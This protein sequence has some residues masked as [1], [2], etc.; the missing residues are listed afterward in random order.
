MIDDDAIAHH[1]AMVSQKFNQ[2]ADKSRFIAVSMASVQELPPVDIAIC[3]QWAS[4]YVL[5]KFNKTKRKCYF[6]QDKEASFYPKG[7]ISAL[8]DNTYG[9]NFFALANTPGLLDWYK[10][11]YKGTGITIK[12]K[13]DLTVFS[14]P[15]AKNI[16]PKA[17]YKV[18]FY[19]RP[20]EPRNAFELGAEAM[21]LL[22]AKYENQILIY[23]A[24]AEWDEVLYGLDGIVENLGKISFDN[25]PSFYR[26]M[27]VGLMF[28]FSGHPGV[29]ASELMASG[30]PTVVNE[31][32]DQTWRGLYSNNESALVSLPSGKA[33][34][35]ALDTALTDTQLRQRVIEGGQHVVED[36]YAGYDA[37]CFAALEH[38]SHSQD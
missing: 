6:I 4:A 38:L 16:A 14:P 30:V 28:M 31:Y 5:L 29:V 27:D 10:S 19:A 37:S 20:G 36:F 17:P 1:Q 25:L 2:L 26:S 15:L 34:F 7:T 24:G 23:A 9:F 12:S 3:T 18:F 8:V 21:K 22:K 13:L 35:E 33:V 11:E 32:D